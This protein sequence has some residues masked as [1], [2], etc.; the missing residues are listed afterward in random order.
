MAEYHV[1][2]IDDFLTAVN[3][4]TSNDTVIL[5]KDID[6]QTHDFKSVTTVKTNINGNGHT[7]YN[8][9]SNTTVFQTTGSSSKDILIENIAFK[10]NLLLG[11]VSTTIGST[12]ALF[13]SVYTTF[14]NVQFHGKTPA[15][16]KHGTSGNTIE[17]CYFEVNCQNIVSGSSSVTNIVRDC[18]FNCEFILFNSANSNLANCFMN[19]RVENCYFKGN[20]N[21]QAT[22][23]GLI[24]TSSTRYS[25][26]NVFNFNIKSKTAGNTFNLYANTSTGQ[27]SIYNTDKI[28]SNVSLTT[29][30]IPCT[31]T[32]MKNAQTLY[33]KGFDIIV[34]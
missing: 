25:Y 15:V 2:N 5:D 16:I 14:S 13:Y 23:S 9:Q 27:K 31:D 28:D 24:Y 20:V 21:V 11:S 4:H 18:Y 32:E 22:G 34:T 29:T 1:N 12:V 17:K 10:N 30:A 19:T 6:A 7:I 33:D 3:T 26:R 8:I